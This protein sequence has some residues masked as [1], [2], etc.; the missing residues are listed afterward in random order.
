MIHLSKVRDGIHKFK[1]I[2]QSNT[3]RKTIKFGAYG[4]SDYTIHKDPERKKRYILRHKD[5]EDWKDVKTAGFW[6]RWIL[7]NKKSIL[8]SIADT[9]KRFNLKIIYK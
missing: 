3:S 9:R 8:S 7:W 5:K 2:I 1:V 4:Y 6:S